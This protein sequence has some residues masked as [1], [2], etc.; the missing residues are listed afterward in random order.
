LV[1]YCIVPSSSL[2]ADDDLLIAAELRFTIE[3]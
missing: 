2:I 1:V 3:R